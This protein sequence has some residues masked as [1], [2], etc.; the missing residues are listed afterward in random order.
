M[1]SWCFS[2]IDLL[3]LQWVFGAPFRQEASSAYDMNDEKFAR[4]VMDLWLQF[5]KYGWEQRLFWTLPKKKKRLFWT[6]EGRREI[7]SR[8]C[9]FHLLS[10]NIF[11][12]IRKWRKV[13]VFVSET[14]CCS[15]IWNGTTIRT[16]IRS[17][18][19]WRD[20]TVSYTGENPSGK[21]SALF[22][23]DER[24]ICG[25]QGV[26]CS[27]LWRDDAVP[28]FFH[29]REAICNHCGVVIVVAR[30]DCHLL[31]LAGFFFYYLF[32]FFFFFWFLVHD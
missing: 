9:V 4:T 3:F 11:G 19:N 28:A 30:K 5:S 17:T 14:L 25:L 24:K 29:T 21:N 7:W 2:M 16:I 12:E 15:Q 26:H 13:P 27:L 1:L 8:G 22:G 10:A 18:W 23:P 32:I 20:P 31:F 6:Q